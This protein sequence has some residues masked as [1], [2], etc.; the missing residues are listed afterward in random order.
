MATKEGNIRQKN[1]A[2]IL[3]VAKTEFVTYGYSGASMKRIA[4]QA[5]LPRA[6]IHYY[7]KN[8]A[9][10]YSQLL[11]EIL[12]LWNT[13]FDSLNAKD[14]ARD[15]LSAYIRA[16]VMYSKLEPQASRIFASEIIHGA[17]H[18]QDYL[19]IEFKEWIDSKVAV[20]QG[21]IE[22]KQMNPIN[23]YHLLFLIWGATQ[24]YADFN[25]Q[26]LSA[27]GK[28]QLSDDDYESVVESLTEIILTGCGVK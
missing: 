20:I 26:I 4:E 24:H 7:F 13:R 8:K 16:K 12:T 1:K 15:S 27:T 10:L 28:E 14:S 17:P 2:H 6:N 25:V 9:D 5:N 21:W 22:Q 19:T 3:A 11:H 23:P 18:L